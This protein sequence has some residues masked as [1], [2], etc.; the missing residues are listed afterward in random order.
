M[1]VPVEIKVGAAGGAA[2]LIEYKAVT[3]VTVHV[4]P[5]GALTSTLSSNCPFI[6]VVALFLHKHGSLKAAQSN[7]VTVV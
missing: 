5:T 7:F 1:V 4:C 3:A 6:K 2:E